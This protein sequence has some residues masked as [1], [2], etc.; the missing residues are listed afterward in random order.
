VRR[1]LFTIVVGLTAVVGNVLGVAFLYDMP[2][3]YRPASL[4][5]WVA[6]VAEQRLATT[7][8]AVAFT[9]GLVALALWARELGQKLG[10]PLARAGAALVAFGALVNAAGTTAPLVQAVH[11]GA[12]GPACDAVGRA[13]LGTTL[14][15][16]ALFNLTVGIGLLLMARSARRDPWVQRLMIASGVAS[17][18]VS[19]QIVWD[20]AASLLYVA[21]PLWLLLV[22][23]TS[24]REVVGDAR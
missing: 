7:A 14:A 24:V 21:G 6:A 2:S 23:W 18:P 11:V 13:L 8:S 9:I 20:P 5:A 15:F 12:C 4:D 3:A 10:E 22:T 1:R 16:D 19:A 17:V